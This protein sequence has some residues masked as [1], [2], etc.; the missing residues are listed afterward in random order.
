M[1]VGKPDSGSRTSEGARPL[2]SIAMCTYNGKAYLGDQLASIANQ[3]YPPDELVI[4]DDGSTDNTLQILEQF[5][6]EAP[7]RV[8][9]YRNEQTLGPTKNFEKAISLCTGDVIFLS[10][11]DDVWMPHKVSVLSQAL[12]D[13]PDAGYVFSDALVVDEE[14][15]PFGY[16]MWTSISFTGRQRKRFKQGHQ[17]EVLLKHNVV[18]GAT[19]AFRAALRDWLLP[20]PEQWVHDAWIALLASAAGA[21]GISIEEPLIRYRQHCEQLIGGKKLSLVEQFRR[22]EA[23]RTKP[24]SRYQQLLYKS[25]YIL[26]R[27]RLASA[28]NL[29]GDVGQLFRAKIMHLQ[30]RQWLHEHPRW[31]RPHRVV[32]EAISGRYHRFSNGWRSAARDLLL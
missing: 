25:L 30:A 11:Q 20:I 21:G 16:T 4:C 2:I 27:D 3:T 8:T 5:S 31:R 18:T 15:R 6:K 1:G 19:M 9:V 22:A 17:L 26:A 23:Y 32:R 29:K 28:G 10:D 12:A 24:E 14:L 7:F 13:N